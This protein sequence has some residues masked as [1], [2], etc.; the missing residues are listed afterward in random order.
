MHGNFYTYLT[1]Y[2][3]V[4][5]L[6]TLKCNKGHIFDQ[7]PRVHLRGAG[8]PI[9]GIESARKARSKTHEQFLKEARDIHGN[10]YKYLTKYENQKTKIKL[11]C[12]AC[13]NIFHQTPGA[14]LRGQGCPPCGK[15]Q[16]ALK[17]Y[18]NKRITYD[19]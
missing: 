14:H 19:R 16:G 10:S 2:T 1:E 6:M 4:Q 5:Y 12:V 15:K 8:C 13:G 7:S 3:G 11:Q 17:R 9:C 18:N